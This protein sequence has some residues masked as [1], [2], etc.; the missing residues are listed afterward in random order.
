MVSDPLPLVVKLI[1][2]WMMSEGWTGLSSAFG[3]Y[4]AS[5]NWEKP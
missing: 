4:E 5:F 3:I 2:V 1:E